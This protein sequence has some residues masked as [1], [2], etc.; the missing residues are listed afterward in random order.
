M[1]TELAIFP[2]PLVLLPGEYLPLR[3]FEARY[4]DMVANCLRVEEPFVLSPVLKKNQTEEHLTAI[5]TT[6]NIVEW[7][8]REDTTLHIIIK[9]S[10]KVLIDQPASKS[11]GLIIAEATFINDFDSELSDEEFGFLKESLET[12]GL[13]DLLKVTAS[14]KSA[15]EI[16]YEIASLIYLD[17][18]ERYSILREDTGAKKLSLVEKYISKYVNPDK[19]T[20]LH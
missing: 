10:H 12:N 6:A 17:P 19:Y 13:Y 5:G 2:L 8:K 11:N 4:L 3:I 15:T 1:K 18:I 9:G 7:D 20:T 16:A 14:S